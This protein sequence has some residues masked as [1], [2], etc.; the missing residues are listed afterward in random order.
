MSNE[1]FDI[2]TH[3]HNTFYIGMKLYVL[4]ESL[5]GEVLEYNLERITKDIRLDSCLVAFYLT[6]KYLSFNTVFT[7]TDFLNK[8]FFINKEEAE[9]YAKNQLAVIAESQLELM[10]DLRIEQEEQMCNDCYQ[11]A[12]F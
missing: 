9:R 5:P 10:Q 3:I 12:A 1:I 6:H 4:D 7:Y 2:L 8:K 11:K